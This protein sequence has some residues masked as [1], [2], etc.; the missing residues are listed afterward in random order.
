MSRAA[1]PDRIY[2]LCIEFDSYVEAFDQHPPFN[3][4]QLAIHQRVIALRRHL[5]SAEQAIASDHFLQQLHQL[6]KAWGM[7]SRGARLTELNRFQASLRR[8]A[9]DIC[10]LEPFTIA[11]PEATFADLILDLIAI[12]QT[13]D[14]NDN[15]TTVVVGS[16]ALHHLLP[17]LIPR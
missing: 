14:I 7:A 9:E 2:R 10:R 1:V 17:D 8:K 13:L 6:L 5:G 15:H 11:E 16:K 4:G 12:I 3:A